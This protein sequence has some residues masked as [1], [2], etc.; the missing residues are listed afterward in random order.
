M[1][2][3]T[4]A[5]PRAEPIPP[6][7]PDPAS[8]PAAPAQADARE[9]DAFP[10]LRDPDAELRLDGVEQLNVDGPGVNAALGF[11]LRNDPDPRIRTFAAEELA[12]AEDADEEV[13]G[14]LAAALAD[15]DPEVVLAAV[16]ALED[17]GDRAAIPHLEELRTHPNGLIRETAEDAVEF[18]RL[19]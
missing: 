15:P 14:A 1:Y 8:A 12:W 3:C 18:L 5:W 4:P 7:E 17:I 10:Q 9:L 2:W 13:R 16:I 19:D 11:L 6:V